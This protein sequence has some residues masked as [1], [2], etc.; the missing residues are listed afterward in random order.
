MK[1]Q[2]FA[3]I[4][5]LTSVS[6]IGIVITQIFWVKNA[7]EL[8]D[9]QFTHRVALGLKSVVNHLVENGK[10]PNFR[11]KSE[12]GMIC[13]MVDTALVSNFNPKLLDSSYRMSSS[14]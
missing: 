9:E 14:T 3:I 12:C 10:F 11:E 1:K 6:I 4:V 7:V 5:F 2:R 8:K 13:G